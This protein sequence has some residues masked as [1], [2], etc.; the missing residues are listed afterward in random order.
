MNV[1]ERTG[2]MRL[3]SHDRTV[4]GSGSGTLRD[5]LSRTLVSVVYDGGDAHETNEGGKW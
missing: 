5:A 3:S 4:G 1:V 2:L